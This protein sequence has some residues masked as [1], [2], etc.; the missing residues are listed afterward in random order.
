VIA[1]R[2]TTASQTALFLSTEALFGAFFASIFLGES[3]PQIG[4]WGC[5]LIF[6]AILLVELVPEIWKSRTLKASS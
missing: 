3:I 6:A 4:Y 2:H 5:A 1:Q